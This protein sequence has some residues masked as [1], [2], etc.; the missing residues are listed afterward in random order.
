M[1]TVR[2]AGGRGRLAEAGRGWEKSGHKAVLV[3]TQ[4]CGD[5]VKIFHMRRG[6][7]KWTRDVEWTPDV[8]R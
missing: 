7:G 1:T 3:E 5:A 4:C 6:G 8:E 2:A